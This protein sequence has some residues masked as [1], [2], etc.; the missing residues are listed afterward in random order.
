MH[1][2]CRVT[3]KATFSLVPMVH[4]S[5]TARVLAAVAAVGH[6]AAFAPSAW[7][8]A[9]AQRLTASP[10]IS[11]ASLALRM[12]ESDPLGSLEAM[13]NAALKRADGRQQI[14]NGEAGVGAK[15]DA[16]GLLYVEVEGEFIDDGYV[17]EKLAS[18]RQGSGAGLFGGLF[19]GNAAQKQADAAKRE[20]QRREMDVIQFVDEDAKPGLMHKR[21][22]YFDPDIVGAQKNSMGLYSSSGRQGS[23]RQGSG[24]QGSAAPAPLPAGWY[25][26]TD[27]ASGKEYYYTA[28]GQVT[29]ERPQ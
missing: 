17:D 2:L 7:A 29:W 8:P 5:S 15:S 22:S 12:G 20:K 26:A 18:Y 11:H 6:S 27:Q 13:R 21:P 3:F 4:S 16:V 14:E 23:G 28:E 24:R 1:E 10:R 19:G 25:T 9:A